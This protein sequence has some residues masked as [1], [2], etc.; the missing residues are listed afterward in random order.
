M[1]E[2]KGVFTGEFGHDAV[3]VVSL[4]FT[5][6]GIFWFFTGNIITGLLAMILGELIEINNK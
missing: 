5:L 6:V 1:R 2:V 3:V 4:F